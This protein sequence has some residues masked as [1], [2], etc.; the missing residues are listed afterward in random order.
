MEERLQKVIARSGITSRRKAEKLILEGK[1]AVNGEIVQELG[2]KADPQRDHIRVSGKLIHLEGLEYLALNKPPGVL[3]AVS[4]PGGRPVVTDFVSS[5]WR[6]YPA[7][8]LDFNSEGLV[9]L[10]ND[11]KLARAVTTAGSVSKVYRV[12]V[13]GRPTRKDIGLLRRGIRVD[14]NLR[15]ARCRIRTLK[16]ANNCWYEVTLKQGRNRQIRRMF[17]FIEHPVMRLRRIAIGPVALGTLR[18]GKARKLSQ[19]EVISLLRSA[20]PDAGKSQRVEEKRK[21]RTVSQMESS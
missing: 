19:R 12:K 10:T 3:T 9:I 7:G 15:Y 18:P 4:D 1:V 17:E 13:R 2:C 14:S 11:G 16:V 21:L 6:I 8:R 5:R 20:E